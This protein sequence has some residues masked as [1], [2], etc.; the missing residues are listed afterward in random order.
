[1]SFVFCCDSTQEKY[2]SQAADPNDGARPQTNDVF[3]LSGVCRYSTS[4]SLLKPQDP[5]HIMVKGA[6]LLGIIHPMLKTETNWKKKIFVQLYN[7][8]SPRGASL[9]TLQVNR[10]FS[11]SFFIVLPKNKLLKKLKGIY[12]VLN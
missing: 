10:A 9:Y 7:N 11:L 6:E 2:R 3:E 5:L 4:S 1:M 8:N 12:E